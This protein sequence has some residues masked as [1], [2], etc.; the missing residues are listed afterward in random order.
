MRWNFL[1]NWWNFCQERKLLSETV[2]FI[3]RN[4]VEYQLLW[5]PEVKGSIPLYFML[6]FE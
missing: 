6:E 5:H 1:P 4:D 2:T 3:T